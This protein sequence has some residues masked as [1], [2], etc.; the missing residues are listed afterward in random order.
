MAKTTSRR[1]SIKEL[2]KGARPAH[3]R[4][5]FYLRPEQ[6]KRVKI[7]AANEETDASAV[8]RRLVDEH[9]PA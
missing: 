4:I 8:I 2:V 3:R 1:S 7:Q 5:A 9:L 6:I